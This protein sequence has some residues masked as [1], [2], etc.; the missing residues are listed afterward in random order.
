MAAVDPV[1]AAPPATAAGTGPAAG[2][3]RID[4]LA[5]KGARGARAAALRIASAGLA[6]CDVSRATAEA[7]ALEGERLTI[8]GRGYELDPA[9]RVLVVGAGKASLAIAEQL[10]QTLGDRLD[11]GVIVVRG[12]EE[13][14]LERIEVLGADHPLPSGRSIAAARRLLELAATAR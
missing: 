3:D 14:P 12:G 1:P 5:A 13:R 6:A 7:V 10:E 8:D 11:S 2:I 4:E 9:G